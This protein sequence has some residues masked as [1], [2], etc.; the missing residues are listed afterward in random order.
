M[1]VV[2]A[3]SKY[4]VGAGNELLLHRSWRA[5]AGAPAVFVGHSQPTH[6]GNVV[7]LAEA[8]CR[9]GFSVHAGDLRG[10]GASVSARQPLG[11]L[12]REEGWERLI[13]DMRQFT[14]IA[15]DGVPWED[16]LI[17]APNI[18]GLLTLELLK[19]EPDLARNIV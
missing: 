9:L 13:D 14:S 7:D 19:T 2:E 15:F 18:T 5:G 11:H 6:S 1:Q 17:I 10:H 4:V 8:L 3:K 16:R 12:D